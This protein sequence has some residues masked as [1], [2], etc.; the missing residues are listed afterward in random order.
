LSVKDEKNN[1]V[2]NDLSPIPLYMQL[3]K[4][5]SEKI[6]NGTL[7]YGSK[8]PSEIEI[9][10]Q[11]GISRNTV[12]TSLCKLA[13]EGFL[14]R[15]QGKGTFVRHRIVSENISTNISF[16][17]ACEANDIVPDH[18]LLT[19]ALQPAD[20]LDIQEL[21]LKLGD[22]VIFIERVLLGDNVPVILDRMYLHPKYVS[23]MNED[24]EGVSLYST[25][26][27]LFGITMH[28]SHKTIQLGYAD[29]R[30]AMYLQI[31][32]GDP[33]LLMTETIFDENGDPIHHTKQTI[34]GD[35]YKYKVY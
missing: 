1:V 35:R 30:E 24:L 29:E 21:K 4:D 6:M 13:D 33:I 15:K 23:L 2:L 26:S 27:R 19:F 12:R 34:L 31:K 5:I 14:V 3:K 28:R 25:L 10:H 11:Y 17:E 8:L 7:P 16:T 32:K 22:K 18:K 20:E 9:A